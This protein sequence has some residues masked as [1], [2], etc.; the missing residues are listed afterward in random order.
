M[1]SVTST[2]S[3]EAPFVA[4]S[5]LRLPAYL[6]SS[7]YLWRRWSRIA[8]SRFVPLGCTESNHNCSSFGPRKWEC[9]FIVCVGAVLCSGVVSIA[10]CCPP[11][12][13]FHV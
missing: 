8:R 1:R 4:A 13:H 6:F 11:Q 10:C 12:L 3:A 2:H 9:V 5:L 7:W